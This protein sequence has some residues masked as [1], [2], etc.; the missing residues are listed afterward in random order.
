MMNIQ[1]F[2]K[3]IDGN[4][5]KIK[6]ESKHDRECRLPKNMNSVL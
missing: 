4:S 1:I 2:F 3:G 6:C 5:S